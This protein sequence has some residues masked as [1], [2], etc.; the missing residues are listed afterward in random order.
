MIEIGPN[1]AQLLGQIIWTITVLV[2]FG[3]ILYYVF[4]R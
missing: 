4:V 3:T 2:T 1:L